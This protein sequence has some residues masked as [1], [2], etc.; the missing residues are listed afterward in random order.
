MTSTPRARC[1][2]YFDTSSPWTYLAFSRIREITARTGTELVL[3]PFLV[4]GVFNVNNKALYAAR[5]K[6][7]TKATPQAPSPKERWLAKDLN[8]WA[9]FLGL[10]IKTM[11]QRFNARTK[12][13]RPGHPISSVKMLRGAIVAQLLEGDE[14]MVRFA[15]HSFSAYWSSL[16]DVSDLDVIQ[17]IWRAAKLTTPWEM[18]VQKM[19][20]SNIKDM[21]R[22]NTQEV[23]DRGGFGSPSIYISRPDGEQGFDAF[24]TFG[25]DRMELVEAKCLQARN[26]PWRFHSRL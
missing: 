23:I 22:K 3:K 26:K 9:D 14:A 13:G 5:D 17:E 16:Q 15:M 2:F 19:Q 11:R 8:D 24:F 10:D 21:L 6:L 7:L 25:N 18:F 12:E 4:G 1:E 20:D